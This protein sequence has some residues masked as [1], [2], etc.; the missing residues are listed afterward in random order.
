MQQRPRRGSVSSGCGDLE[1]CSGKE[2]E[3]EVSSAAERRAIC[4]GVREG[5]ALALCEVTV[6]QLR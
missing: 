3:D 6:G 4:C 5:N 2:G 1:G